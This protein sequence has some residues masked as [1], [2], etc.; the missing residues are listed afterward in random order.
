VNS[1]NEGRQNYTF[2]KSVRC[3]G[4]ETQTITFSRSSY[5]GIYS[6]DSVRIYVDVKDSYDYDNVFW[7]YG[8]KREEVKVQYYSSAPNNFFSGVLN[9]LR[10]SLASRWDISIDET[11]SPILEGYDLYIFEHVMPEIMPT[12]GIVFLIDPDELPSSV[13]LTLG[14]TS[15][16]KLEFSTGESHPITDNIDFTGLI[17]SEYTRI[18]DS[19]DFTSLLY[20]GGDPI[21]LVKNTE[22][23]KMIVMPFSLNMSDLSINMQFPIMMYNIFNYFLP[24]TVTGNAFEVGET[25]TLNSRGSSL[26]VSYDG[27][28]EEY[29]SLP[30]TM[31]LT[32]W[33]TYTITQTLM[34]G[35]V[36]VESIYVAIPSSESNIFKVVDSLN[37]PVV[38]SEETVEDY[39]LAMYFAAVLVGLM[40]IEWLLQAKNQ[41]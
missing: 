8:G 20:C 23:T 28:K 29:A 4:D 30:A 5:T 1:A 21:L 38:E 7:L 9:G 11:S 12:D 14:S 16:K 33:G 27:K 40:F 26:T 37:A 15:T 25:V 3:E 36:S 18:T 24:A 13:G 22:A 2:D 41:M 39:K 35:K 17:L 32:T 19:G 10:T 6:Y 34:S 31:E